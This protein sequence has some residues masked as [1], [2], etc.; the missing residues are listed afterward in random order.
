MLTCK[1]FESFMSEFSYLF[2]SSTRTV[3]PQ[4]TK[5]IQGLFSNVRSNCSAIGSLL[6]I[7]PQ[8]LN[9]LL[10]DSKW[11]ATDVMDSVALNFAKL[12]KTINLYDELCLLIDESGFGKK[13]NCSAG[14]KH[15]YNGQK[16]KLDN[17]QVG[18]FGA[19]N[20]GSLT[21]LIKAELHNANN[22]KTKI[23][24]AKEIIEHTLKTLKIKVACINF[25]SFYG[26]ATGLL[27]AINNLKQH[28]IAD[29][30]ESH[31][32]Y[33]EKF[34]M[35]IPKSTNTRGRK[36]TIAKPNKESIKIKDYANSLK[37]KD[38]K[39]CTIRNGSNQ[40]LK[41]KYHR[42]SAYVLNSET[43]KPMKACLIIRLDKDGSRYYCLTNFDITEP[44]E[45]VAYFQSKRYFIERSFQ[46]SKSCLGMGQYE[47]RSSVAWHKHMAL[48][49]LGLLFVQHEKMHLYQKLNIYISTEGIRRIRAAILE[50]TEKRILQI[51]KT[52]C[53]KSHT[54]KRSLKN[55]IYL[56]I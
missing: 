54:S 49:M 20:G 37:K 14:V 53:Q 8:S 43:Q 28:Y 51:I 23:D 2:K 29:V 9:H 24:L 36:A 26:R 38:F 39:I 13:G 22:D 55:K 6:D 11:S 16:G 34:Q 44:L 12:M 10:N 18:V 25:D 32:I 45:K 17:C 52:E 27:A 30:P 31:E 47:V 21:A 15:Q 33:L 1:R 4:A 56:R 3:Y 48:C 35:R 41:A 50:A 5:Y 40:V 46:D 7:N 42:V 19:L